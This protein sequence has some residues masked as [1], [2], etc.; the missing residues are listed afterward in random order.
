MN[1][2]SHNKVNAPS[3]R[4]VEQIPISLAGSVTDL[5]GKLSERSNQV[6]AAVLASHCLSVLADQ[7]RC[8]IVTDVLA[9]TRYPP[10]TPGSTATHPGLCPQG[11]MLTP[12]AS[13]TF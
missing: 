10:Q 9:G 8:S 7:Y 2:C 6:F 1:P 13:T 11:S 12:S 5:R 4:P 3:L